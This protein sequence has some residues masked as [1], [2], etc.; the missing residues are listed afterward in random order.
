MASKSK[1][2]FIGWGCG[3][4]VDVWAD[5]VLAVFCGALDAAPDAT[6]GPGGAATATGGSIGRLACIPKT[7]QTGRINIASITAVHAR[8]CTEGFCIR[9]TLKAAAV[10]IAMSKGRT[11]A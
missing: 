3:V 10:A 1:R 9:N 5:F 2:Q 7:V 4:D 8:C 6:I 11:E